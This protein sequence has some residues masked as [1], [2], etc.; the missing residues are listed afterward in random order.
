[1][2]PEPFQ[3]LLLSAAIAGSAF[4]GILGAWRRGL[5]VGVL[6]ALATA[7]IL[8][9]GMIPILMPFVNGIRRLT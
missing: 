9:A 4:S 3:T 6:C 7:A 2:D 5:G 1:M 8:A